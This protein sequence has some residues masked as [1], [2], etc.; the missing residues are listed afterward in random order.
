MA[1][2][3]PLLEKI[4]PLCLLYACLSL[5]Y[6]EL[7][8]DLI[9]SVPEFTDLF[10][11]SARVVVVPQEGCA[12]RLWHFLG[13]FPYIAVENAVPWRL[14]LQIFS[15][16]MRTHYE[17]TPIQTYKQF[18]TPSAPRPPPPH[19]PP[20]PP[21]LKIFRYKLSYFFFFLLLT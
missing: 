5:W 9:V 20:H 15:L 17:N 4:C 19:P 13:I 6:L 7:G 11:I 12:L 10:F 8:V 14:I 16:I 1:N 2:L 21:K 18:H 3:P